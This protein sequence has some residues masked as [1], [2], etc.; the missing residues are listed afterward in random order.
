MFRPV[1]FE[2]HATDPT[3]AMAFY[4]S[5]LGWRFEKWGDVDY[6][7]V[8]TSGGDPMS[9][10]PDPEPGINGGLLP[11]VGPPPSADQAVNAS[12]LVV[13]VPDCDATVATAVAAGGSIALPPETMPGVGRVG[14]VKDPDGNLLGLISETAE[15]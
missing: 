4:E 15:E 5:V 9:T 7:L 6:W 1:H 12:V 10:T 11:R 3:A 8:S 14:Y 2:I 13:G